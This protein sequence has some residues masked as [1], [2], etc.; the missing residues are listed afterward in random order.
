[1]LSAMVSMI[2]ILYRHPH[3]CSLILLVILSTFQLFIILLMRSFNSRTPTDLHLV[4]NRIYDNALTKHKYNNII[5]SLVFA[6]T[7]VGMLFFGKY[8][9]L[10]ILMEVTYS[11]KVGCRI[12]LVENS[13]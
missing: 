4:L 2:S 12:N 7:I 9:W 1:M 3:S 6:G 5:T 13:A 11:P 10:N 8:R